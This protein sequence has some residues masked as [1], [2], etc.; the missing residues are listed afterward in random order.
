MAHTNNYTVFKS[1]HKKGSPLILKNIWDAGSASAIAKAGAKAI[2]TGSWSVAAAQGYKDGEKLPLDILLGIA[3][4]IISSV[5]LPCSI[6]FET[7]YADSIQQLQENIRS[8]LDIGIVGINFEDWDLK[9]NK[10]RSISEQSLHI[11][12]IKDASAEAGLPL[13][14]NARTDLFLKAQQADNAEDLLNKAIRRADAYAK[15]GAD[16]FFAPALINP[17]HIAVLC[18]ASPIPVNIMMMDGAPSVDTLTNLGVS[19][20]SYGPAPYIELME[21]LEKNSTD[22]YIKN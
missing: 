6:D 5:D 16:G 15:A 20:I 19:R 21:T 8:L 4:R 13:F 12:A 1:L 11:Q 17:D 18:N 7:G 9:T 10:L 3:S 2:A 22:L 14:I